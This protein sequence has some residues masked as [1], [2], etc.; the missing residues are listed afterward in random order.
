MAM[1]VQWVNEMMVMVGFR[2]LTLSLPWD[3]S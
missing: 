2:V 3:D 1:I